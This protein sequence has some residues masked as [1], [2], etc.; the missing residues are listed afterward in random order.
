V[1]VG[2][3]VRR[4]CVIRPEDADAQPTE[5]VAPAGARRDERDVTVAGRAADGALVAPRLGLQRVDHLAD[6]E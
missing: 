2:V 5:R 6:R 4:A 3:L 1:E